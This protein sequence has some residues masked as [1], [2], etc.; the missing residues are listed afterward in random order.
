MS[1]CTVDRRAEAEDAAAQLEATP[2]VMDAEVLDPAT[3]P[4]DEW[5]IEIVVRGT[6]VRPQVHLAL[7]A[8]GLATEDQTTRKASNSSRIVAVV[9]R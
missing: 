5:T 7:G 8:H 4:R 9:P 1:N 6:D 2:T 3:G